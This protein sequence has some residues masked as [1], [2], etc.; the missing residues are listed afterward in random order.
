[1]FRPL[2]F[3]AFVGLRG[4]SWALAELLFGGRLRDSGCWLTSGSVDVPR[5]AEVAEGDTRL[6]EGFGC[7]QRN[8]RKPRQLPV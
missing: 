7:Q 2:E 5:I 1:M 6:R 3:C 4:P 8:S